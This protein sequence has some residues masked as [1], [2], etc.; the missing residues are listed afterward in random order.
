ML[1]S[2]I[3]AMT[4]LGCD[5]DQRTCEY[6]RTADLSLASLQDCRARMRSEIE[7]TDANYPLLVAI[8][9]NMPQQRAATVSAS[10]EPGDIASAK[11]RES[12]APAER[13]ILVRTRERYS[14]IIDTTRDGFNSMVE[15]VTTPAGW[16]ERQIA[17]ISGGE[18]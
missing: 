16:L 4:I 18:W 11:T 14:E 9:E 5:C 2:A 15:F 10:P 17:A 6:V 13:S 7:R 8:C 12:T 3:V 1:K